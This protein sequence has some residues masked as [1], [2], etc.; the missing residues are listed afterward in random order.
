M[1]GPI[2][3]TPNIDQTQRAD[4]QQREGDDELPALQGLAGFLDQDRI[5]PF[6]GAGRADRAVPSGSAAQRW[7]PLGRISQRDCGVS[8]ALIAPCPSVT[9]MNTSSSD[10]RWLPKATTR[11]PASIIARSSAASAS[12]SPAWRNIAESP[13]TSDLADVAA[14]RPATAPGLRRSSSRRTWTTWFAALRTAAGSPR[15]CRRPAAGPAR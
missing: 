4:Q 14:G 11:K 10:R 9:C 8:M 1:S 13:F 12:R 5:E 6:A 2:I 15:P 7:T 3:A